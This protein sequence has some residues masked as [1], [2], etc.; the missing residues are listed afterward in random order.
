M[1]HFTSQC[2]NLETPPN[3]EV[4]SYVGNTP[5]PPPAV[6]TIDIYDSERAINTI[7]LP[8]LVG[9]S[10]D[11]IKKYSEYISSLNVFNVSSI[12]SHT[13]ILVFKRKY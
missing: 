10:I 11:D 1:A 7:C 9:S 6:R 8:P 3:T 4:S 12:F 13:D 2:Q 5:K